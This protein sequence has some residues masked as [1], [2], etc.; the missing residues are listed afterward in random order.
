VISAV[1]A[2]PQHQLDDALDQLVHAELIFRRGTPPDAEY[3]FKHALVQDAAYSTLLRNRRQQIHARIATTLEIRFPEIGAIQPELLAHHCDEAGLNEKAV[4]Y[5]FKAGQQAAARS[6]MNEA[7]AQLRKGLDLLATL[8]DTIWRQQQELDLQVTIVPALI[9]TKGYAAPEVGETIARARALA[10]LLKRPDYLARLLYGQWVFRFVRA[11]H[12]LA[13]AHAQELEKLGEKRADPIVLSLGHIYHGNTRFNLGE[14]ATARA[15]YDQC[16]AVFDPTNRSAYAGIAAEEPRHVLL[17]YL[18][19]TLTYLGLIDQG[20]ERIKEALA[21]AHQLGHVHSLVFTLG[22]VCW[23]EWGAGLAQDAQ[24]HSAELVRL[25]TEHGFP[26]WL[27][28]GIIHR[29]W[30]LVALGQSEEGLQSITEGLSVQS[31]TGGI[32]WLPW[33]MTL[34]AEAHAKLGQILEAQDCIAEAARIITRTDERY[35]EAELHRVRGDLFKVADD[36]GSAEESYHRALAVARNQSAK[37]L[38]LRAATSLARLW[39]GQGK[40]KE[41]RDLLAPIYGWFT[42]GFDTPVL[43]EAKALLDELAS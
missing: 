34:V 7:V 35:S 30:S 16:H 40:S 39:R 18:A 14:F 36:S 11:E 1:A 32:T 24:E 2:M 13:L 9:A 25:A 41:A 37:T 23:V 28:F 5:W 6:S 19:A 10:E 8:P 20:R 27:G 22:H 15:L 21:D 33:A 3:T 26:L 17:V 4:G 38:E 31:A 43:K 12:R 29:G 42:E